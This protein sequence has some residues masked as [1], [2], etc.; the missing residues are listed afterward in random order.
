VIRFSE[1]TD[2]LSNIRPLGC[3]VDLKTLVLTGSAPGLGRLSDLEALRGLRLHW[4]E[5]ARNPKLHD[6]APLRGMPLFRLDVSDTAASSLADLTDD[7]LQELIVNRTAIRDLAPLKKLP[8]LRTFECL[9]CPIES[10]EPLAG[11]PLEEI[12]LDFRPERDEAVLKSLKSL[13]R[14]NGLSVAD[15][16][17]KRAQAPADNSQAACRSVHLAYQ[18]PE[19]RAFYTEVTVERSAPGTYFCACGFH[20]GYFGIQELG[21][22]K[23]VVIFS[24]WD[25]DAKDPKNTADERRVKVLSQGENVRVGRF[26]GEG[27]GAQSF[28]DYEWKPGQPCRFLVTAKPDGARTAYTAFVHRHDK[29]T[30]HRL[31]TFSTP[32]HGTLLKGYY[33]FI[34]DFRRNRDSATQPRSASYGNGWVQGRDGKWL[35]LTEARFTAD[36]TPSTNINAGTTKDAIFLA[37]GGETRNSGIR[38]GETIQRKPGTNG[39]PRDLPAP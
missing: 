30:W 3:L 26:D 10:L 23:K 1:R 33:S 2:S 37:T 4:L 21:H 14:I 24:V 38:L 36:S 27:T 19:G 6:L 22:G 39:P 34:E 29:Q 35:A 12:N 16:W 20:R 5:V 8:R 28:L 15:F 31:A 9:G 17:R 13:K 7:K 11:R 32:T 25:A 18:A